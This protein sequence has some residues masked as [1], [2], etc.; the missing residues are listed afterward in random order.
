MKKITYDIECR[1]EKNHWWFAGRRVL[2]KSLVRS[3]NV[4]PDSP[5]IDVG[6]GVGSNLE[7]LKSMSLK[8]VGVDSEIYCLS[9][10]KKLSEVPLVN[11]DL[12][13]L[14]IKSNTIGLF[15]ATDIL[16]HLNEDRIGIR[17][18]HRSL[19]RG[20]KV[21]ITVPSFGF[22]WGIQDIAGMHK[23]RYS[24]KELLMKVEQAGLTVLKSSY[25]NF[26]LFAPIFFVRSVIRL[27]GLSIESENKVNFPLI[28]FFLKAI[29]SL[30][31]SLLR[32]LSFPFGVSIVC[33]ARK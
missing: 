14:P 15:I 3:L 19:K 11:G 23:R 16:E 9:L 12:L 29:F 7:L 4:Q 20:G 2:L 1:I 28:N 27:T 25:F 10:A 31:C 21:I 13:R 8:V 24:R 26:F 22:L 30:E 18:I 32:Y 5:T 17:E 33:I 6:C